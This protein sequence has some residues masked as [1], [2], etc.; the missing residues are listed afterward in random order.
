MS[1]VYLLHFSEK[2]HHARHYIGYA[3]RNL[4]KRIKQ[5]LTGQGSKLT[6]AVVA[7]GIELHLAQ[8]WE[9]TRT[10]ERQLKNR[11]NAPRLCPICT[12][13]NDVTQKT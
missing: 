1:N 11:K 6:K 12:G 10:F 13:K 8:V 4:D 2:F 7:A 9:G 5:H 3:E